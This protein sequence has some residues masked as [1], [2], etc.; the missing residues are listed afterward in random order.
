[1]KVP[2]SWNWRATVAAVA[3]FALVPVAG[4]LVAA[5][6]ENPPPAAGLPRWRRRCSRPSPRKT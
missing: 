6:Q 3:V 5:G 2:L 4:R 1:M